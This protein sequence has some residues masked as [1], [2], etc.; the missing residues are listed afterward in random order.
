MI[1]VGERMPFDIEVIRLDQRVPRRDSPFVH[2]DVVDLTVRLEDGRVLVRV[3]HDIGQL[4]RQRQP[5]R[6]G[7][8]S[9][10]LVGTGE[11]ALNRVSEVKGQK[12]E[13]GSGGGCTKRPI[14]PP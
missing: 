13:S 7:H 6:Q 8:D 9:T 10:E 12:E 2:D 11:T 3:Q 1:E 5:G 14:A 4:M